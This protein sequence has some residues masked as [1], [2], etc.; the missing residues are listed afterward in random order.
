MIR[1]SINAAAV[2]ATLAG[3]AFAQPT[4]DGSLAGDSYGGILWVQNQPT[5][6][7]NNIG[8]VSGTPGDPA[9]VTTGVEMRIPLALL[10]NPNIGAG[11]ELTAFVIRDNNRHISN[12]VTGGLDSSYATTRVGD[13]RV[14]NF[15]T[16]ADTQTLTVFPSTRT[17]APVINGAIDEA[18]WA[19]TRVWVQNRGTTEGDNTNNGGT[20]ATGTE[21]DNLY[22]MIVGTDLYLFF[23]GN[24]NNYN[25]LAIFFDTQ[26][27]GQNRLLFGNSGHSFGLLQSLSEATAG[28]GNGLTFE[29]SFEPE[30]LFL[31]TCGNGGDLHIDNITIPTDPV[32]T[33]GVGTY[34]GN[35]TCPSATGALAGGTPAGELANVLVS[36]N[37]SN[38][39]GVGSSSGAATPSRDIAVGSEI[40]GLYGKVEGGKLYLLVTGNLENNFNKLDLFLDVNPA[41]GQNQLRGDNVNIDFQGLNRMGNGGNGAPNAG[42]GLKF[43]SDFFADYFV[44]ITNG[45]DPVDI[46][47]N[48]CALRADGPLLNSG[49]MADYAAS[50]GGEKSTND[51]VSLTATYA[52]YQFFDSEGTV[53]STDGP[54]RLMADWVPLQTPPTFPEINVVPDAQFANLHRAS[55]DNNN[56]LGVSGTVLPIDV[57]GAAAVTT[58]IELVLD[59]TELGWDG[60]SP[61]KVAGFINGQAHDFISNQVLGG[62]PTP[63]GSDFAPDLGE[64][65]LV[66]F[67]LVEGNQYV[68]IAQAAPP[69]DPDVNQDG[70]VDQDDVSYLIN[71]VG[72]GNNDTG[73]DPD[74][75]RDGNVDQDDVAALINVV[76]GGDCP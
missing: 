64:P 74:F 42:L 66:D 18:D 8:G 65:S 13:P 29:P 63:S 7:G 32:A 48:A 36:L 4:I 1:C 51:P 24:I 67:G 26:A 14:A 10:G 54:P 58:G 55:V 17:S 23:G 16:I 52:E 50:H 38:T 68:V 19:G 71:V 60:V 75:N 49:F 2:L 72:G 35:N 53:L 20:S 5:T 25:K 15:G 40:D 47:I 22:A 9:N 56:I 28:A 21:L 41:D 70:N 11:L 59:L 39:A 27:G 6:F 46:Y 33:P 69:C 57:S 31:V 61:I 12:Q 3:S 37:N 30:Q 73:I 62:L 76:A 45:N 44:G 43:D 34:V